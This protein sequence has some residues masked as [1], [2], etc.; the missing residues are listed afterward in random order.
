MEQNDKIKQYDDERAIMNYGIIQACKMIKEGKSVDEVYTIALDKI[1][2]S[3]YII[4]DEGY[5]LNEKKE[6]I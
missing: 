1:I 3:G 4:D 2:R 6:I 5:L